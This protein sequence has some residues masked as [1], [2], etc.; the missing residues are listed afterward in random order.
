MQSLMEEVSRHVETKAA[1][2][3]LERKE[4]PEW[5]PVGI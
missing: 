3:M 1:G 4:R 2:S 5:R